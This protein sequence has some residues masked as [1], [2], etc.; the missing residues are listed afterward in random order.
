MFNEYYRV[1]KP[2]RWITVEFHNSK[3][4]VWN[5]I[6][7]SL[8]MAGFIIADVRTLDKKKG[9]DKTIIIYFSSKTRSSNLRLQTKRKSFKKRIS[10]KKQAP[11]KLTW[12][13]FCQ[14]TSRQATCK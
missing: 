2:N 3:N 14:R 12:G 9:D 13:G 6:Q 7:E 10:K 8:I 5:A 11:K 4:S 1:L